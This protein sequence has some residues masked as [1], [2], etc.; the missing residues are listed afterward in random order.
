MGNE[1]KQSRRRW[2]A[3]VIAAAL[4]SVVA[5]AELV[6]R[7]VLG[8]GDPPLYVADPQIEYML[9]PDQDVLR[10]GNHILVNQWGMRSLPFPRHKTAANEL[11][12]LVFGD[13]VVNG[14]NQI[15]HEQLATT[16]LA[17]R[18]QTELHRPVTVG[19]V[20]AGSWGPGNWLAYVERYGMFDADMVVLVFSSGDV[21]DN[22]TFEPL[23]APHPTRKPW[24]AIQEGWS[25]YLPRYIPALAHATQAP[26]EPGV[27]SDAEVQRG[28]HD[29]R[30][31]L[32][33]VRASGATVLVLHHP[34]ANEM[35][36]GRDDFGKEEERLL[37]RQ[38]GVPF[39]EMRVDYDAAGADSLY[40]DSI[41]PN[42][43]GQGVMTAVMFR[44]LAERL[45]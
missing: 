18:L 24:L 11:R 43:K 32:A 12:V 3:T 28:L 33:K 13:S 19:N 4:L 42:A 31:L 20:S 35:K 45:R 16:I 9:R 29:M 30:T 21:A 40:R 15:D 37:C 36:T 10:F 7:Y 41:H 17:K 8:L 5:V 39:V 14:G 22:P 2:S 27:P 25:R 26:P 6:S 44:T 23:Q 38:L 34:D 1:R